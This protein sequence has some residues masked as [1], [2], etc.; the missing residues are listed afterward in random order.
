MAEF[1]HILSANMLEDADST[2]LS[3]TE[4]SIHRVAHLI[5]RSRQSSWWGSGT[6]VHTITWN[7]SGAVEM[8]TFVLDKNF[9]L[10]G[11]T[12]RLQWSTDA[13]NFTTVVTISGLDSDVTYWRT[14]TAVTKQYWRL[15]ITGLTAQPKIPNLWAG[16]RIELTFGP[17]GPFD[18]QA[19]EV[20]GEGTEGTGGGGQYTR[21]FTQ[22][23]LRA[24]F[25]HL[26]DAKYALIKS[27]RDQAG[28]TGKNFW[29]LTFPSTRAG[30]PTN[31]DYFPIYFN[32][33]GGSVTFPFQQAQSTRQGSI[34]ANEAL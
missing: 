34:D 22:R 10:D 14:F 6:A 16:K 4:D 1:P 2:T 30:D 5:D 18:P 3:F 27:W 8:D 19:S 26:T 21:R 25:R 17:F 9:T 15:R 33:R 24:D 13:V 28:D 7:F 20:V 32:T 31:S 29:W 12:V 23:V 11:A